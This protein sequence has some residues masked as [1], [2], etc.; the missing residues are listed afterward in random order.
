MI[1]AAYM[2][3]NVFLLINIWKNQNCRV[4]VKKVVLYGNLESVVYKGCVLSRIRT[5]VH[6][7]LRLVRVHKP[8]LVN[9]A[10]LRTISELLLAQVQVFRG[11]LPH[12]TTLEGGFCPQH[13]L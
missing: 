2:T 9:H 10:L 1:P 4:P 7:G 13:P 6:A 8:M 5:K 12:F 3:L 11:G